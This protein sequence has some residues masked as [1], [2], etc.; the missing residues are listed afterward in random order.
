LKILAALFA[1]TLLFSL[2]LATLALENEDATVGLWLQDVS[3]DRC[4][5]R[6]PD[7]EDEDIQLEGE[8]FFPY[9][10]YLCVFNGESGNGIAGVDLGIRYDGSSNSGVDVFLWTKCTAQ[11]FPST[12]WPQSG[13]G[14]VIIWDFI[15]DCQRDEPGGF[16][17]GVSAIAGF[18]YITAYSDDLLE[19][20]PRPNSGFLKVAN[21]EAAE[22]VLRTDQGG[23]LGFSEDGSIQGRRG[24]FAP[25]VLESTWGDIKQQYGNR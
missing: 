8:L 22:S 19:V 10:A 17:E 21:C 24:C 25:E 14:N 11:E 23:A 18:F 6:A 3:R 20:I 4:D 9:Y 5:V 16:G 12:G 1:V 2:P 7:C 13:G 15:N